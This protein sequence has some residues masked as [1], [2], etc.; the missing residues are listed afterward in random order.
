VEQLSRSAFQQTLSQ[1]PDVMLLINHEGLPLARTKAGNLDLST[2]SHGLRMVARLDP[3]DP[4]VQRL[5]PKLKPQPNGNSNMDEMSFSFRVKDQTWDSNYSHR[6][7]NELSLQK[8]DV[9]VVN[10]GMNPTTRVV[11]SSDAVGALAR[12][13]N[14]DLVELR[15]MSR[16]E[17][18]GAMQTL[19]RAWRSNDEVDD[20]TD[21][22]HHTVPPK[23]RAFGGKKAAPFKKGGGKEGDDS[24]DDERS[25]AFGGKTYVNFDGGHLLHDGI[26]VTCA[27]DRAKKPYGGVSYADPGYLGPDRKPAHDGNGVARYPIDESHVQAA[28]S[29]INMPKNQKGYTASQ[30]A[31]IKGKIKAAMKK[32]GHDVSEDKKAMRDNVCPGGDQ[33]PGETCPDHNQRTME[34]SHVEAVRKFGGGVTLVAVMNDGSRTPLPSFRQSGEL[35]GSPAG[36]DVYGARNR[37]TDNTVGSGGGQPLTGYVYN[38]PS[39]LVSHDSHGDPYTKQDLGALDASEAYG[40][41]A[42]A[43]RDDDGDDDK[44][45]D[46]DGD[47]D[48]QGQ[49]ATSSSP[50]GKLGGDDDDDDDKPDDDDQGSRSIDGFLRELRKDA[51]LPELP[52]VSAALDFVRQ[53]A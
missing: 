43:R 40:T 3:S 9:S 5:A 20:D 18:A 19:Q 4:D 51:K 16:V 42:R 30:L 12:A 7:I 10:Y 52:T 15:G 34:I 32:F 6:T 31:S 50:G 26:C 28:W 23:E 39:D 14:K 45:G 33:C 48:D 24:D 49:R 36:T 44:P 13:G 41:P 46:D 47:D 22:D 2:D 8:G 53:L 29:Y 38:P 17:L 37:T 35:T 25:G 27:G 21:S 1:S 11:M